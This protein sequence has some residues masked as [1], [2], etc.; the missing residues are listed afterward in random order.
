MKVTCPICYGRGTTTRIEYQDGTVIRFVRAC[1]LCKEQGWI[2]MP[3]AAMK[4]R[5]RK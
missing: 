4:K 3:V 5:K 2:D 1:S